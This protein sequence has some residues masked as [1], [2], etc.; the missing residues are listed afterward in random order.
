MT[1]NGREARDEIIWV[2]PKLAPDGRPV[3]VRW[4]LTS[5]ESGR[6]TVRAS[7]VAAQGAEH[8]QQV[9]TVFKGAAALHWEASFDQQTV[10]V[11][12]SGMLTV[13]VRNTGSEVA[14]NV[15]LVVGLPKEVTHIKSTPG[16]QA[17]PDQV[18]FEARDIPAGKVVEYSVQFRGEQVGQAHFQPTLSADVLGAEPLRANKYVEIV[19]R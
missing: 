9:E 13:T 3:S 6:K 11:D 4:H 14:R 10:P 16:G 18:A 8:G 2:I 12:R 17:K 19:R 15:R 1:N 5:A 7:A